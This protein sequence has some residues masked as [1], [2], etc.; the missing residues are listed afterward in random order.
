MN[1]NELLHLC[2]SERNTGPVLLGVLGF[3]KLCLL[4][5]Y[6]R[7]GVV[8]EFSIGPTSSWKICLEEGSQPM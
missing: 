7:E 4:A 3:Y 5:W 8:P 2:L 6:C 1:L